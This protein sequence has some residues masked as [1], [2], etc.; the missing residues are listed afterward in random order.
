MLA[1]RSSPWSLTALF[2]ALISL[3]AILLSILTST[4]AQDNPSTPLAVGTVGDMG[5][6]AAADATDAENPNMLVRGVV[7]GLSASETFVEL[8][9]GHLATGSTWDLVVPGPVLYGVEAG[10]L[11]IRVEG[12]AMLTRAG[13]DGAPEEATSGVDYTLRAGDQMLVLPS[14]KHVLGNDG[15]T[16]AA[17]ISLALFPASSAVP[18]WLPDAEGPPGV[19]LQP[20]ATDVITTEV[21]SQSGPVEIAFAKTTLGPSDEIS[22]D[23]GGFGLLVVDA[24]TLVLG[25]DDAGGE[26]RTYAAGEVARLDAALNTTAR[27]G[28]ADPLVVLS[29]EIGL[30]DTASGSPEVEPAA[31]PRR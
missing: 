20:L 5:A 26:R 10:A 17:F 25:S 14:T 8:S 28:G 30:A 27:N 16:P 6:P 7:D 9:R 29:V 21:A 3:L 19:E 23:P 31:T 1:R 11:G 22:L 18:S 4:A 12:P 24:G 15:G 13:S 2:F